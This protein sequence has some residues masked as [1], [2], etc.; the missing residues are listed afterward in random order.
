[1]IHLVDPK[2]KNELRDGSVNLDTFHPVEVKLALNW[3][4]IRKKN[5]KILEIRQY[6]KSMNSKP[7][8]PQPEKESVEQIENKQN[9]HSYRSLIRHPK[10]FKIGQFPYTCVLAIQ[11]IWQWKSSQC[12]KRLFWA[13]RIFP[14][15]M[16]GVNLQA[17]WG[18]SLK[19]YLSNN[20]KYK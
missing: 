11:R 19:L 9:E 15:M 20:R 1:M 6:I 8:R 2:L 14:L 12:S 7:S 10:Y 5:A 18:V 17:M 16:Q 13:S 4:W 3:R